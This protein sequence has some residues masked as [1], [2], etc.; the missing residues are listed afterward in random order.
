MDLSGIIVIVLGVLFFFGS[1]A[2]LEIRSRKNQRTI[3]QSEGSPQPADSTTYAGRVVYKRA[4][5][6]EQRFIHKRKR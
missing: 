6:N 1:V 3:G 5:N 4:V 2:W